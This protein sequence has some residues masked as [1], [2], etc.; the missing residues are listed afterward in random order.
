M[1]C[2]LG[3]Q[4]I[5]D[6]LDFTGKQDILGKPSLSD[7][8]GGI[9]TAPVRRYENGCSLINCICDDTYLTCRLLGEKYPLVFSS[10]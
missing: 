2:A 10:S 9:A 3:A 4:I 8:K 7:L 1:V 6:I 5:D